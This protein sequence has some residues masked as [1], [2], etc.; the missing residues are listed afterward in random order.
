MF[1]SSP[2]KTLVA[3]AA[4][5]SAASGTLEAI[6]PA[7][8]LVYSKEPFLL[9]PQVSLGET[10]NDNIFSR[11]DAKS[12]FITTNTPGVK[13]SV[14]KEA[15]K[16]IGLDYAYNQS[17]YADRSDLNTG[18]HLFHL[19]NK[20]QGQRLVLSGSDRVEFRSNPI[21][22]TQESIS[23]APVAAPATPTPATTPDGTTPSQPAPRPDSISPV[24]GGE[25]LTTFEERNVDYTSQYHGY[26]LGYVISEK[27]GVYAQGVYSDTDYQSGV[28]LY[29]MN[30]M[31]GTGGFEFRAFPKTSFFGEVYYGQ[32]ASTPNFSAPKNPHV[33]FLGGFL[34]TRG[35][36]TEKLSGVVKVGYESR[37]FSDN[38][39]APTDPVVDL[40]L[41]YRFSPKTSISL[42]Y[43]RLNDVSVQF[44]RQSY[45]ADAV[46][47]QITQAIGSA[48]KW[49][50]A[51]G[52]AYA[53][54]QY[55]T[56]GTAANLQYDR[57]SAYF[58]LE[59]R[60]QLW[61]TARLGYSFDSIKYGTDK[62][63][64]YDVNRVTLGLA[65][66]Y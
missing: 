60:I 1:D 52:G 43:A 6:E 36:F 38:T 46:N 53:M 12:D 24:R 40:S 61:L 19:R 17:F 2:S 51:L 30:T 11:P 34:G 49:Q 14:G 42:A 16:F 3:I 5:L 25:V 26:H 28:Q 22:V 45:T 23:R 62:S 55:E 44:A 20:F 65:V 13:L 27:T 31:R 29:D 63:A 57:Y 33:S 56:G 66:G 59:Y 9:R 50:A 21:G 32:T 10:Y 35:N 47:G 7:D 4:G 58:S 41:N 18:E 37:E 48:G 54:Y 64:D 8:I 15:G 39:P